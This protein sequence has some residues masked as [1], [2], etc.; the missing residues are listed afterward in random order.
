M[1]LITNK[2]RLE[3]KE[4][5]L[6]MPVIETQMLIRK[7]VADVFNA[8]IDP[9]ITTQFWFSASTGKL[10]QGKTVVWNWEKYQVKIKLKCLQLLKI[11]RFK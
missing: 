7:P 11:N 2:V 4:G 10:E 6:I 8:F 9:Q 3:Q 1:K 5:S